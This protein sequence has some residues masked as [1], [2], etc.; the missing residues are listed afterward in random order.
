MEDQKLITLISQSL[1]FTDNEK[2]ELIQNIQLFSPEDKTFLGNIFVHEQETIGKTLNTHFVQE[3]KIIVNYIKT[4]LKLYDW[5]QLLHIK[6][7]IHDLMK[8]ENRN[9][10]IVAANKLLESL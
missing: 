9:E 1:S 5:E 8:K 10:D 4:V 7:K 2:A 6:D 3:E